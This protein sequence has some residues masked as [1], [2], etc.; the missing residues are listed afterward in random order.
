MNPAQRVPFTVASGLAAPFPGVAQRA[1][2]SISRMMTAEISAVHFVRFVFPP[3]AIEAFK[4]QDVY[5]VVDHFG[6]KART[7]IADEVKASLLEDLSS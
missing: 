7:R 1:L 2:A 6:E 4:E 3:G 5:L